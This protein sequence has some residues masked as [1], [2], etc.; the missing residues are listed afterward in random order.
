VFD[1]T[2]EFPPS[3][4]EDIPGYRDQVRYINQRLLEIIPILLSQSATPPIIILQGDH[5]PI[6]GKA[7]ERMKILNAYHLPGTN[8][9]ELPQDIS[10]VNTFRVVF[11]QY[12]G[13]DFELLDNISYH[14][15]YY[16]PFDFSIVVDDRPGCSP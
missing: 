7:N 9:V 12:F 11:D 13:G 1:A 14:S 3:A 15:V 5:G 6:G 8:R 4:K 16:E 10:P 2:G